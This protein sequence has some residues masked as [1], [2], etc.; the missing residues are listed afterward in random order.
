MV[1]ECS[2]TLR[3]GCYTGTFKSLLVKASPCFPEKAVKPEVPLI[4]AARQNSATGT[5]DYMWRQEGL[6]DV[7]GGPQ[8]IAGRRVSW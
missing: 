6:W 8:A 3:S 7:E 1:N 4:L 2:V 5:W